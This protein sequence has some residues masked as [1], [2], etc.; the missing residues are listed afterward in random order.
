MCRLCNAWFI[1]TLGIMRRPPEHDRPSLH[2]FAFQL[3]DRPQKAHLL[4]TWTVSWD[5][6]SIPLPLAHLPLPDWCR[7]HHKTFECPALICIGGHFVQQHNK[8]VAY[9]VRILDCSRPSSFSSKP[10]RP[11]QFTVWPMGAQLPLDQP[12]RSRNWRSPKFGTI[13]LRIH[14][15]IYCLYDLIL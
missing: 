9:R 2:H 3:N 14:K 12:E 5:C 15:Q 6:S 11:L 4:N 8:H 10:S 1:E 7:M 13:V